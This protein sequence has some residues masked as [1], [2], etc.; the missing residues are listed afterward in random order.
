MTSSSENN[1]R[2]SPNNGPAWWQQLAKV[3]STAQFYIAVALTAGFALYL[4]LFPH[5][6]ARQVEE[7]PRSKP[8]EIVQVV[9]PRTIQIR[10]GSGLE[11][12]LELTSVHEER[13]TTPLFT[14]T[15]TVV[16]SM[17]SGGKSGSDYWQFS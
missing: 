17:R 12:K 3:W 2:S 15:G 1:L 7:P 6:I 14:V 8:V 4:F 11:E 5:G 16:A 10:K 9:A 13:I